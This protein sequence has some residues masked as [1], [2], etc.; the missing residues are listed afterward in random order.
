MAVTNGNTGYAIRELLNKSTEEPFVSS[1]GLS[2]QNKPH[3]GVPWRVD[4]AWCVDLVLN[5]WDDVKSTRE[6]HAW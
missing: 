4:V 6:G 1:Y 2:E 3:A 5:S